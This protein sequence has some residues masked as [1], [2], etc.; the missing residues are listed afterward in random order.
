MRFAV[1]AYAVA[2][3]IRLEKLAKRFEAHEAVRGID[4][5][6]KRGELVG[7][8]GPNGAGKSTTIKMMTGMLVPRSAAS[9]SRRI[10]SRSSASWAT[11]PRPAPCSRR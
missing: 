10:R 8:L 11:C 7:L 2:P 4:L 9:T 5:H 1:G 3:M 6:I